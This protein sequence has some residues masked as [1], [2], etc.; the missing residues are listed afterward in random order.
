M[1][2][3]GAPGFAWGTPKTKK[4]RRTV[5]LDPATVAALKQ[6]QTR[7]LEERIALGA[8]YSDEDLVV[9]QLDGTS[10]HPKNLSYKFGRAA[11]AAGLPAI[12]LHDLRHT[13]ATHA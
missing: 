4:G 1:Q 8:S 13:R 7:Q 6:H 9:C 10:L 12:R 2:R 11:K 5:A 3:K